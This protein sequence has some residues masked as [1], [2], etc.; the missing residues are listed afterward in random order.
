MTSERGFT[1]VAVDLLTHEGRPISATWIREALGAGNVRLAAQLLGR[2]YCLA[3][4]VAPGAQ[5]GRTLGFPTANI[6]PPTARALPADGAEVGR[7]LLAGNTADTN[8]DGLGLP[9]QHG[10]HLEDVRPTGQAPPRTWTG[11]NGS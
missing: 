11:W 5:R 6:V 9:G 10:A 7:D 2:P 1:V 3:G 4:Q 8:P